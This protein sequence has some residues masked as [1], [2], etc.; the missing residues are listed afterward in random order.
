MGVLDTITMPGDIVLTRGMSGLSRIIRRSEQA[1]GESS[2]DTN[3]TGVIGVGGLLRNATIIEALWRVR[4]HSLLKEY[5][6]KRDLV[7]IYR[8][9]DLADGDR[10]KIV[11]RARRYVGKKYG[12]W[13]LPAHGLDSVLSRMFGRNVYLFRKA[14]WIDDRPICSWVTAEAYDEMDIRFCGKNPHVCQPDDIDDEVRV[15]VMYR[16]V[17]ALTRIPRR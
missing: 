16:Q 11:A 7:S 4:E 10:A 12:W 9:I 15:K 5:G 17:L 3:H 14:L 8:R 6:G 1:P 2:S 13:K